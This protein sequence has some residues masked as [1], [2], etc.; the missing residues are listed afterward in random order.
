LPEFHGGRVRPTTLRQ[1]YDWQT[2]GGSTEV[3][4]LVTDVLQALDP[5]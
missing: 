5:E 1:F 3:A 2:V 4:R